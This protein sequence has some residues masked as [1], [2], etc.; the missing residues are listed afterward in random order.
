MGKILNDYISNNKTNLLKNN[1]YK[2]NPPTTT[3]LYK[4]SETRLSSLM[5]EREEEAKKSSQKEE[6]F[7]S[8]GAISDVFDILSAGQYATT[9]LMEGMLEDSG[10]LKKTGANA[11]EG[12]KERKSNVDLLKRIG[13]E[14]GKGGLLTGQYEASTSV[15]GNFIKEIPVTVIGFAGDLFLDPTII[16]SKLGVF[17]KAA[18][19]PRMAAVA[20]KQRSPAVARMA[21]AISESDMYKAAERFFVTRG[22]QSEQFKKLDPKRI[23]E[24]GMLSE[25]AVELGGAT[26]GEKVKLSERIINKIKRDTSTKLTSSMIEYPLAMRQRLKQVVEGGITTNDDLKRIAE[27]LREEI[28]LAGKAIIDEQERLRK[29]V[30]NEDFRKLKL[31]D[32]RTYNSNK[33]TYVTKMYKSNLEDKMDGEVFNN[34]FIRQG[35]VKT[36]GGQFKKRNLYGDKIME[37]GIVEK[38]IYKSEFDDF[39]KLN[40]KDKKAILA[41]AAD[42]SLPKFTDEFRK[43]KPKALSND[44]VI[45]TRAKIKT[46][47]SL[48]KPIE[49]TRIKIYDRLQGSL[50]KRQMDELKTIPLPNLDKEL[51]LEKIYR[52]T[53]DGISS[54]LSNVPKKRALEKIVKEYVEKIDKK[55]PEI[56]IRDTIDVSVEKDFVRLLESRVDDAI[57]VG[58]RKLEKL[59][60]K[61]ATREEEIVKFDG[62]KKLDEMKRK[63]RKVVKNNPDHLDFNDFNFQSNAKNMSDLLTQRVRK[64]IGEIREAGLAETKTVEQTGKAAI[65]IRFF[66]DLYESGAAKNL[67]DNTNGFDIKMPE[68]KLLGAISGKYMKRADAEQILNLSGIDK[69]GEM[70]RKNPLSKKYLEL[71]S[72][73]KGSKLFYNPATISRNNLSNWMILN[74]LGG[75]PFWR[76]DVYMRAFKGFGLKSDPLWKEF[77]QVGGGLSDQASAELIDRL[78]EFYKTNTDVAKGVKKIFPTLKKFHKAAADFYGQQDTFFKFANFIKGKEDGLVPMEAIKRANTYLVDYTEMPEFIKFLRNSPI[79]G[80]PF[81][82]FTYGVSKPLA[83]TLLNN[84]EKLSAYHKAIRAIQSMNPYGESEEE[85]KRL[86]RYLPESLKGTN[87]MKIPFKDKN[88]NSLFLD[89]RYIMPFNVLEMSD[90]DGVFTQMGIPAGMQPSNPFTTIVGD[91]V[92][93]KSS[94]T[95]REVI[96]K[97]ASRWEAYMAATDYIQKQ[98]LPSF[99]LGIPT[100]TEGKLNWGGYSAQRLINSISK[101]GDALTGEPQSIPSALS[102]TVLGLK[103]IPVDIS[104]E[105]MFRKLEYKNKKRDLVSQMLKIKNRKSLTTE[106]KQEELE[107]LREK[108][109]NLKTP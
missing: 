74:P 79:I 8:G 44:Q 68:S 24:E 96:P 73:W 56:D 63:I 88:G 16:G 109:R 42:S 52:V 60:S 17:K 22:G 61:R 43:A 82:S 27:P 23:M 36:P 66:N 76:T 48:N 65:R 107:R 81:I 102:H 104:Q 9:G 91:L 26:L 40:T 3:N 35:E 2:I 47:Q 5:K 6:G 92:R 30:G 108:L 94:F 34:L 57:E 1:Y 18:Q 75:L 11:V 87:A 51:P 41:R 59:T 95:G 7:F 33:G 21:S 89:L 106:E 12:L 31:L 62:F 84:P 101:R 86:E 71:M 49:D 93:N 32:E 28:D 103:N 77:K 85:R 29:L 38:G 69:N 39:F 15:F 70:I 83:K 45:E 25:R 72:L 105:I 78:S 20:L 64:S 50:T 13:N 90:T 14:T 53:K 46:L 55:L 80:V 54:R 67:P 98:I 37:G 4:E 99:A 97:G 10:T 19:T 100:M 58:Q